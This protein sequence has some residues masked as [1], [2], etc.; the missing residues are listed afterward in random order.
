[1][2]SNSDAAT[3]YKV[4]KALHRTVRKR[5]SHWLLVH[6]PFMRMHSAHFIGGITKFNP[7]PYLGI[8]WSCIGTALK[9]GEPV[10]PGYQAFSGHKGVVSQDYFHFG[11]L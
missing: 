2:K 6:L 4:A 1:M 9:R 5:V 3:A 10:L 8:C 7:S 11:E